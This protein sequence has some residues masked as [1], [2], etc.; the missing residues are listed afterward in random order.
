MAAHVDCC[1]MEAVHAATGVDFDTE[2]AAR[3]R[4]KLQ[5]R[6]KGG[7]IKR[8]TDTKYP[9]LLGALLDVLP[10]CIDMRDEHGEA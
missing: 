2:E 10:R 4:L 7:R 1:I 9:E 5:A 3:E 8:A 6:M